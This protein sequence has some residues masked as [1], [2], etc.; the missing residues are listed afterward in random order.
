LKINIDVRKVTKRGN[1]LQ[2]ALAIIGA[3]L[4]IIMFSGFAYEQI[5]GN[6]G[7]ELWAIATLGMVFVIGVFG[8]ALSVIG[9]FINRSVKIRWIIFGIIVSAIGLFA[10]FYRAIHRVGEPPAVVIPQI[11]Y[12]YQSIGIVLLA[13][14]IIL[15]AL[16]LLYS[17][18]KR[19]PRAVSSS[20]R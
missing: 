15:I 20:S 8:V 18:R 3:T 5:Y 11:V 9:L 6:S 1:I 16:S 2:K 19:L 12:P 10:S 13:A 4:A 14:G 17:P 7:L